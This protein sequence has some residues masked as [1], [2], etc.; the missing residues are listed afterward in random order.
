MCATV[1]GASSGYVAIV[2]VPAEVA[3]VIRGADGLGCAKLCGVA[4]LIAS[5]PADCR[6]KEA[7]PHAVTSAVRAFDTRVTPIRG[8]SGR[9][10]HSPHRGYTGRQTFWPHV[11]RYRLM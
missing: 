3:T 4:T 6:R 5:A 2:K 11:T 9:R 10:T 8:H 7:P 1:T